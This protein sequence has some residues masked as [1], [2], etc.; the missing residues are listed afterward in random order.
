VVP[1]RLRQGAGLKAR[2]RASRARGTTADPAAP[3]GAWRT[4][5]VR[6]YAHRDALRYGGGKSSR[7]SD[8]RVRLRQSTRAWTA[9]APS[10]RE[11]RQGERPVKQPPCADVSSIGGARGRGEGRGGDSRSFPGRARRS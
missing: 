8:R 11:R 6:R 7:L 1:Q 10:N 4:L 2:E 3:E 9:R 5:G